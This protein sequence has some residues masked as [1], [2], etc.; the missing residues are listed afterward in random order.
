MSPGFR[1]SPHRGGGPR[2]AGRGP[3]LGRRW[4]RS[5]RAD[6]TSTCLAEACR[7]HVRGAPAPGGAKHA[8]TVQPGAVQKRVRGAEAPGCRWAL[9]NLRRERGA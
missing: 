8:R 3:K 2:R 6:T 7:R 4:Q 5:Q 9:Q 1:C